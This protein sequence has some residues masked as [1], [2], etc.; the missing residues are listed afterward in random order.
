[1]EFKI[2][3]ELSLSLIEEDGEKKL[4]VAIAKDGSVVEV[5]MFSEEVAPFKKVVSNLYGLMK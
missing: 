4:I 1:M 5:E 2:T 3:D